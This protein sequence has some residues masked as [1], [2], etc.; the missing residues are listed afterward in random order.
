MIRLIDSGCNHRLSV[1]REMIPLKAIKHRPLDFT[2]FKSIVN[3]ISVIAN[4][5]TNL[6]LAEININ[7]DFIPLCSNS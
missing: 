4:S 3:D 2:W 6:G 7:C 1:T 5:C